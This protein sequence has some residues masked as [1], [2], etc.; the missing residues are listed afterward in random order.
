M[1]RHNFVTRSS[2][3]ALHDA[4]TS[5]GYTKKKERGGCS[6]SVQWDRV[7]QAIP[8]LAVGHPVRLL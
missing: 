6:E 8:R 2:E 1:R 7:S 4:A 3:L 5:N